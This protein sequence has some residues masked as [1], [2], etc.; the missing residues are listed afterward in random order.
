MSASSRRRPPTTGSGSPPSDWVTPVT[1]TTLQPRRRA[2]RAISTGTAVEPVGGE[3]HHHVVRPEAEV[4][5]DDLG[6]AG[7]ALD[8][9]RLPLAV[10]AHHL[11]VEGH[12][13]LH[14]GVEA[15]EA[16]VAREHLLDRDARVA[17]AEEMHQA[18][19]RRWSRHTVGRPHPWPSA[20]V[21]PMCLSSA[22][23]SSNQARPALK[24][25]SGGSRRSTDVR[26]QL[27]RATRKPR[28]IFSSVPSKTLVFVLDDDGSVVVG[29]V[30]LAEDLSQGAS[31]RPGM[32][33]IC[34]PMPPESVPRSYS[35][36]RSIS[37]PWPGR[38][39]CARRTRG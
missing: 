33:G 15:G 17:G 39:G 14:D 19:A 30:E 32:R 38:A 28:L 22:S 8:E 13:Q 36:S 34:Q 6:Q 29:A 25:A 10:G 16:A 35:P 21:A 9:H 1:A 18:V 7:H 4:A 12:R 3:D 5:Q 26:S 24:V 27:S 23:A 31:P 20:W 2:P 37:R 11:G